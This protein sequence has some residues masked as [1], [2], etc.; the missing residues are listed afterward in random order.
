MSVEH[1]NTERA[2]QAREGMRDFIVFCLHQ[3]LSQSKIAEALNSMGLKRP[4]GGKFSQPHVSKLL[5][6]LGLSTNRAFHKAVS[7]ARRSA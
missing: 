5:K 1:F 2:N 4:F 6:A 3:G 7:E